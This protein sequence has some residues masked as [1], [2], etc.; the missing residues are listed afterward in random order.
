M[1]VCVSNSSSSFLLQMSTMCVAPDFTP[2]CFEW[3]LE[4]V[5]LALLAINEA[6]GLANPIAVAYTADLFEVR[7]VLQDAYYIRDTMV[8]FHYDGLRER[9]LP[10]FL[11]LLKNTTDLLRTLS[12]YVILAKRFF[13]RRIFCT[14]CG[15]LRVSLQPPDLEG[16]TN[17]VPEEYA[18]VNISLQPRG[19]RELRGIY[20]SYLPF[21]VAVSQ[22]RFKN[23]TSGRGSLNQCQ[24]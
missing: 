13:S 19:K 15:A 10:R 7:K 14:C 2:D 24:V 21:V 12:N 5:R 9:D 17:L 8:E 22:N 23:F 3:T 20:W 11:L 16:A 18:W 4:R 1:T 6:E